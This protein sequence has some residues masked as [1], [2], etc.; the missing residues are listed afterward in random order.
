MIE[1]RGW[2]WKSGVLFEGLGADE[3]KSGGDEELSR[4]LRWKMRRKKGWG[5]G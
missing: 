2:G 1:E 4:S 5:L 3:S